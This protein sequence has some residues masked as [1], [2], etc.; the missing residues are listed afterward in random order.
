MSHGQPS[1][2]HTHNRKQPFFPLPFP[3]LLKRGEVVLPRLPPNSWTHVILLSQFPKYLGPW[4]CAT[5]TS[6]PSLILVFMHVFIVCICTHTQVEARGQRW[7][8]ALSFHHAGLGITLGP[9]GLSPRI[10]TFR[11]DFPAPYLAF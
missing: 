4:A 5:M 7:E 9:S 8:S 6:T 10:T 1:S 2:S 11:A 3:F